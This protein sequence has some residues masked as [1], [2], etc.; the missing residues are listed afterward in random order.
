M[1]SFPGIEL[2]RAA[3]RDRSCRMAGVISGIIVVYLK[4][5][6]YHADE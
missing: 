5:F 3:S 4:V 1:S 6:Q 2:S